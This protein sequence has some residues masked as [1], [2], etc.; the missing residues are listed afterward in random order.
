[1][2][3]WKRLFRIEA[4]LGRSLRYLEVQRVLARLTLNAM[5]IFVGGSSP[6]AVE[7]VQSSGLAAIAVS[8]AVRVCCR[9]CLL[10]L[11][12]MLATRLSLLLQTICVRLARRRR[13][14]L[15]HGKTRS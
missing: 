4:R 5:P 13:H 12:Q 3:S 7:S 6:T 2:R 15:G 10:P 14:R 8:T 11:A 9:S 1:M